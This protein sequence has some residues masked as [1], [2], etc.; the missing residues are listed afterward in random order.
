MQT[1]GKINIVPFLLLFFFF[2]ENIKNTR[3]DFSST[4]WIDY[5]FPDDSTIKITMSAKALGYISIGFGRSMTS[6]DMV[7]GRMVSGVAKVVDMWSIDHRTPSEDSKNDIL[8]YSGSRT[9]DTSSFTFTRKLKTGDS[10]DV[11]IIPGQSQTMVWA[12]GT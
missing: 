12:Y 7:T 11:E 4:I 8:S 5:E 9:V 3:V 10:Q 1:L 6:C 2:L